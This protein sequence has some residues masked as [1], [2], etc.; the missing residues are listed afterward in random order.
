MGTVNRRSANKAL[1]AGSLAGLAGR[2]TTARAQQKV[3]WGKEAVWDGGTTPQG[4]ERVFVKRVSEL[5]GGQYEIQLFAAGQ[6]V[7]GNQA[8][9]AVRGGAFQMM[10]TC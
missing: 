7:P 1:G 9:D 3:M 4:F 5:T 10:K 8:F 2:S 6:L